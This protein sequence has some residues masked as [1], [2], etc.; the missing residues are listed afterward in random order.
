MGPKLLANKLDKS[1]ETLARIQD[2]ITG[3][4]IESS[5]I[6]EM[7][8]IYINVILFFFFPFK[9][10]K[11]KVQILNE[12]RLMFKVTMM[13]SVTLINKYDYQWPD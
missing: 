11:K 4:D 8:V 1:F 13:S 5:F 7:Y 6:L 10:G 9:W 2:N 3:L 12:D